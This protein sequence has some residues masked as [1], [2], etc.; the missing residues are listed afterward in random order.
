MFGFGMPETVIVLFIIFIAIGGSKGLELLRGSKE[1]SWNPR[2]DT[3]R[4][5]AASAL[6]LGGSYRRQWLDYAD[7]K[8]RAFAPEIG[9]DVSFVINV[10][11]Y[12][13]DRE[14]KYNAA[15][16]VISLGFLL[17]LA[18]AD[19]S[20]HDA[21]N[22]LITIALLTLIVAWILR[23]YKGH[24]EHTW[25]TT[26]FG[27]SN[28]N[29]EEV[30]KRFNITTVRS[31][32]V[33]EK[34]LI[35][36]SGFV[37]F[38]GAGIDLGGWSFAVDISRPKQDM[39][40]H[41][42]VMRFTLEELYSE[43]D[44]SLE[45]LSIAGLY[46]SDAL[47]VSG[48]DI[49]DEKW[50]LP[51]ICSSPISKVDLNIINRFI[52]TNDPRIRHF[53]CVRIHDSTNQLIASYFIRCFRQGKSLFFDVS[54]FLLTPVA[55]S[56]CRVDMLTP[57][58]WRKRLF[59]GVAY[60]FVTPFSVFQSWVALFG[61]FFAWIS[62]LLD[63]K[64]KRIRKEIKNN[65]LFDYGAGS[66][67]RG[68]MSSSQ[69]SH[70]FQRADKEMYVKV[71]ERTLLDTIVKFLNDHNIDTSDIKERQTSIVNSGIIVQ[72][73]DVRAQALAVGASAQAATRNKLAFRKK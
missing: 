29:P 8:H 49:R 30:L 52:G 17:V 46:C 50:I 68:K 42:D 32:Y 71:I 69:Y 6:L 22:E 33:D 11:K 59:L 14:T 37:P 36:Y 31:Q 56:Y 24:L 28:Y 7:E 10:C 58:D 60:L 26:L 4:Y 67:L 21:N 44:S 23:V 2:G 16:F 51:D 57:Y 64:E 65:P 72:G 47:F 27:V 62:K 63:T 70:F 39:H 41:A 53:R 5:L 15:F 20:L 40:T 35:I 25:A 19:V 66:S 61:K 48:T 12:L 55:K 43:L 1:D 73:G 3:T 9:V 18:T 54:L 45:E 13:E 38:V 34:N